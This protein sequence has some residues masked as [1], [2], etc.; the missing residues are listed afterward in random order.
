MI[1]L[2]K[3][4]HHNNINSVM[5]TGCRRNPL[6][7]EITEIQILTYL[8]KI[9]N[10]MQSKNE[11]PDLWVHEVFRINP[12]RQP[13]FRLHSQPQPLHKRNK[14]EK[15]IGVGLAVEDTGGMEGTINCF[16]KAITHT[17]LFPTTCF[18]VVY[19]PSDPR[20]KLHLTVTKSGLP[21]TGYIPCRSGMVFTLDHSFRL[22][23]WSPV[24]EGCTWLHE[25]YS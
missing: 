9:N 8:I 14:R 10:S 11:L 13:P 2:L 3:N 12:S 4:H 5:Q 24:L 15:F 21:G 22:P 7:Q 25:C 19:I 1:V 23:S 16:Y 18:S 17:E 6:E 20:G